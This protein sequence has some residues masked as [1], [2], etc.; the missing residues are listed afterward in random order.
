MSDSTAVSARDAWMP[1][2]SRGQGKLRIFCF[3]FAGGSAA[4]FGPLWRDAPAEL[5]LVPME[6]PG[7]WARAAEP[8]IESIEGLAAAAYEVMAPML[9]A[10]FALF[11][12]SFGALIAFE[13]ARRCAASGREP[14]HLFVA[15]CAAPQLI[16][17]GTLHAVLDD[18]E[19]IRAVDRR[20]ASPGDAA[21]DLT[22]A[23]LVALVARALRADFKALETYR[24]Q[25][26]TAALHCPVHVFGG[27]TD[28]AV[29]ADALRAWAAHAQSPIHVRTFDGG[30]FFL[31]TNTQA[32]LHA[33]TTGLKTRS[34]GVE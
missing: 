24:Y 5:D 3:P 2:R 4:A 8:P 15:A 19:L 23:E 33:I 1:Y 32:L 30:H 31:R 34:A 25:P 21:F 17:P 29:S 10:P 6:L 20:Y 7:R 28:A 9:H 26:L 22:D 27:K 16:Q 14:E 11:G 12:Y 13:V 18:R